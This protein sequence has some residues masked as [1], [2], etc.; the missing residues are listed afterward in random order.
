MWSD[1]WR[2]LWAVAPFL[3]VGACGTAIQDIPLNAPPSAMHPR[4]PSTVVVYVSQ[5]PPWPYTEVAMLEGQ[6]ASTYSFDRPEAVMTKLR[7][8]AAKK[9]CDAIILNG[10]NDATV[11]G[12]T[13]VNGTGSGYV[14]TL[15]GYRTTC[16]MF[17]R[18][19]PPIP[20]ATVAPAQTS[21]ADAPAETTR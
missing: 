3:G 5:R 21:V 9:G 18:E 2:K 16:V 14:T 13:V 7:A 4:D 8:Y 20:A 11:G 19:P 6:R 1:R 12:A 10:P 15:Q 17:N